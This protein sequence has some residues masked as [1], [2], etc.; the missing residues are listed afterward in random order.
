MLGVELDG[1]KRQLFMFDPFIGVVIDVNK[2][3]KPIRRQCVGIDRKAVIL[4]GN[5]ALSGADSKAGLI[6]ASV[7]VF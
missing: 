7:A 2:P 6:L 1:H 4:G 3:R 5:V